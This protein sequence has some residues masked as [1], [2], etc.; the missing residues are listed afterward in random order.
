MKRNIKYAQSVAFIA[1]LLVVAVCAGMFLGLQSPSGQTTNIVAEEESN[2]QSLA[3]AS[4]GVEEEILIDGSVSSSYNNTT[5]TQITSSNINSIRNTDAS[6]NYYIEREQNITIT[7]FATSGTFSGTLDGNGSTITMDMTRV[8]SNS[9]GI[10]GGLFANFNGTIKNLNIVVKNFSFGTTAHESYIGV[11]V[12]NATSGATF[13]NV[14]LTLEYKPTNTNNEE[15]DFYARQ[16]EQSKDGSKI[17]LGGFAG[18]ASGITFTDCTF[19]NGATGSYGFALNGWRAGGG[20]FS[21]TEGSHY[22]GA[23]VA[24]LDGGTNTMKNITV[25]GDPQAKFTVRNESKSSRKNIGRS[26]V[27]VGE[28]T[29]NASLSIHGLI[30]AFKCTLES[31]FTSPNMTDNKAGLIVGRTV[32]GSHDFKDFYIVSSGQQDWLLGDNQTAFPG[33]I[34]FTEGQIL[35]FD[36]DNVAY[37]GLTTQAIN[38]S[39]LVYE[40]QN[41]PTAVSV[42]QALALKDGETSKAVWVTFPKNNQDLSGPKTSFKANS[43]M[44][45]QGKIALNTSFE[46]SQDS[47]GG[48][49]KSSKI[50]DGQ[51]VAVPQLIL[52]T[53]DGVQKATIDNAYV[54]QNAN[55]NA[56]THALVYS[57][58]NVESAGYSEYVYNGVT[59]L[60]NTN[61]EGWVYTAGTIKVNNKN[62]IYN[63]K[64]GFE[65]TVDKLDITIGFDADAMQ[66]IIYGDTLDT[67]KAK[68]PAKVLSVGNESGVAP[69]SLDYSIG[70]YVEKTNAGTEVVLTIEN[71]I[72]GGNQDNYNITISDTYTAVIE[73]FEIT[74]ALE[75]SQFTSIEIEDGK[76]VA[77]IPSVTTPDEITYTYTFAT[78]PDSSEWT[79]GM[80]QEPNRYYVVIGGYD[81]TNYNMA[82]NMFSFTI[83]SA[84]ELY[85][86]DKVVDGTYTIEYVNTLEKLQALLEQAVDYEAEVHEGV[87]VFSIA[88]AQIDAPLT[89]QE[90]AY[91]VTASLESERYEAESISFNLVVNK[92]V[93]TN[94]INGNFAPLSNSVYDGQAKDYKFVTQD[95][96][97]I[98]YTVMYNGVVVDDGIMKNAGTYTVSAT[99]ADANYDIQG[100][101]DFEYVVEKATPTIDYTSKQFTIAYGDSELSGDFAPVITGVYDAH[102]YNTVI[103]NGEA[104]YE[105]GSVN[106]GASVFVTAQDFAIS[107]NVENY[108]EAVIIGKEIVVG[109]RA[110]TVATQ[111]KTIVYGNENTYVATDFY[112]SVDGLFGTDSVEASYTTDYVAGVDAGTQCEVVLNFT[113]TSG[114]EENYTF[115]VKA[116][117][118]AKL[119][120]EKRAI[121]GTINA[122]NTAYNGLPYAGASI[123]SEGIYGDDV[124]NAIFEYAQTENGTYIIYAPIDMGTY[125]VKVVGFDDNNYTMA[126]G[127]FTNAVQFT[128]EGNSAPI[129]NATAKENIVYRGSEYTVDEV[130]DYTVEG[131]AETDDYVVNVQ[132]NDTI[133]FA[134][135]Y[136]ITLTLGYLENYEQAQPVEV[137]VVVAPAQLTVTLKENTVAY[138]DSLTGKELYY[139]YVKGLQGNDEFVVTAQTYGE[140][141]IAG[142]TEAGTQIPVNIEYTLENADSYVVNNSQELVSYLNVE[143]KVIEGALSVADKTYDGTAQTA[144]IIWGENGNY[145]VEGVIQYYSDNTLL[146]SAPVNAGTYTASVA[147]TDNKNYE[148]DIKT[149]EFEISKAQAPVISYVAK[150]NLVYNG[151]EF[152]LADTL[153]ISVDGLIEEDKALANNV[154]LKCNST[155]LD[156]GVYSVTLSLSGLENYQNAKSVVA[157]VR[158]QKTVAPTIE[159]EALKVVYNGTTINPKDTVKVSVSGLLTGDEYVADG[160]QVLCDKSISQAGEYTVNVLLK[161]MK[162]YND[163]QSVSVTVNVEKGENTIDAQVRMGYNYIEIDVENRKLVEYSFDGTTWTALPSDARIAID[164]CPQIDVYVRYIATDN[165]VETQPLKLTAYITY[166]V[167]EEYVGRNFA[168][169][170]VGFE[171]ANAI[172]EALSWES[173]AT[174]EKSATYEQIVG[175]VRTDYKALMDKANQVIAGA[176][177]AGATMIGANSL[178]VAVASLSV[179][180]LVVAV[181]ALAIKKR[182]GGKDND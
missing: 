70:G 33:F 141:Y 156:A 178:T 157:K 57:Q 51:N 103:L 23:F 151:A 47:T 89:V 149:A 133:K 52:Q 127:S 93:V 78:S 139:G 28:M 100:A 152:A 58:Q 87:F 128:I 112:T 171:N 90:Q 146:D 54:E 107:E 132:V 82:E 38:S 30:M 126:E 175:K 180:G 131:I 91:A 148:L 163:A 159:A 125:W 53:G 25:D 19:Y 6:G 173:V 29:N 158:V 16:A 41:G 45:N 143:K 134:G 50:Y 65:I 84:V 11:V 172:N 166:D 48:A 62:A 97:A 27:F 121:S 20:W 9:A 7:T 37:S 42:W 17:S 137:K 119:I 117:V 120:V 86:T 18:K 68:N 12:G 10:A 135:E 61:G 67:V 35:R 13:E 60:V 145:G 55:Y 63:I 102:S 43:K 5:G 49:Y 39:S 101:T 161:D 26:G 140:E 138:G 130:I 160:V 116:S 79:E 46:L 88:E 155:I 40:L 150:D 99:S 147:Q 162:N 36:G 44:M 114:L 176:V 113:F 34:T 4:A 72:L 105:A 124:V 85:L 167:I 73:K 154:V 181:G 15:G 165:T 169:A 77:Y 168:N 74:G 81:T 174:G 118:S 56:G 123:T 8:A 80:P 144:T 21:S 177:N 142:T 76:A 122:Q 75:Q 179:G 66:G 109:K 32:S 104:V 98:T 31:N 170:E 136:T 64:N 22:L 14:K 110:V 95:E 153:T 108:N 164:I 129:I 59:Y 92:Q 94:G 111:D 2:S 1:V 182:K 24:Y 71:V 83:I 69:D 106:A 96:F 115:G 3:T